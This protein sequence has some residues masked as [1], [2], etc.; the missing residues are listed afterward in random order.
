MKLKFTGKFSQSGEYLLRR[1]S[2]GIIFDKKSGQKSFV[3]R[4]SNNFY[5]RFH[6]YLDELTDGFII[7]IHLDQ[8][9]AI[10]EGQ[11][12]H[13]GEYDSE[14]VKKEAIRIKYYIE[15]NRLK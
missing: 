5:P 15:Q 8:K 10:Y 4:L 6:V 11:T 14:V 1:L 9:Q 7:S 12:A 13:S 3:R 2:Y